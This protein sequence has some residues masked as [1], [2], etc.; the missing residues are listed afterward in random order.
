MTGIEC[1]CLD[2]LAGLSSC[3]RITERNTIQEAE[4][5]FQSTKPWSS[6]PCQQDEQTD[7]ILS[8]VFIFFLKGSDG[9]MYELDPAEQSFIPELLMNRDS[10]VEGVF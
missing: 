1:V 7:F 10:L 9:C 2:H 6:V 5:M 3:W 4:Q 8:Q